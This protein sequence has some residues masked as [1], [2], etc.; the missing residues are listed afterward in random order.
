M[1]REKSCGIVPYREEGGE[2]RYLVVSSAVTRRE[3][4]EFPKGGVEEGERET[5]TA[6]RE[7]REETGVVDVQIVR[8]FREPIHYV[9]RRPEGLISKQVIY[10]LGTVGDPAVVLREVEC[11]DFRWANFEDARR[12]LRHSNAKSLLERA[13]A[14]ITGKRPP[15]GPGPSA[16]PGPAAP[17]APSV[18]EAPLLP[19]P[20][21]QRTTEAP[22]SASPATPAAPSAV[23]VPGELRPPAA[24]PQSTDPDRRRRRRRRRRRGRD[25]PPAAA[26][27]SSDASPGPSVAPG[28]PLP[29]AGGP[30]EV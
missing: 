6:L 22:L 17:A 26:S 5:D 14:R 3:H 28:A 29:P 10:F 23:A 1:L 18:A 16:R 11:K 24:T 4:W 19:A 27:P 2:V 9:Y 30:P 20:V 8:G 15:P 21:D 7:L 12:L 13:H 25:E